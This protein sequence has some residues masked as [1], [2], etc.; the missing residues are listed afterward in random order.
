MT[1]KNSPLTLRLDAK[2]HKQLLAEAEKQRVPL[3]D[4]GC[5]I[6]EDYVA[7]GRYAHQAKVMLFRAPFIDIVFNQIPEETVKKIGK[8]VGA[9]APKRMMAN[10][11]MPSTL[12]NTIIL[13]QNILDKRNQWFKARIEREDDVLDL[14]LKH[15]INSKWSLFLGE[16]TV[17]M[18]N[19]FG[20]QKTDE[21]IDDYE[22]HLRFKI[23]R[24]L[25]ELTNVPDHSNA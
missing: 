22:A 16:F 2:I 1:K 8:A 3:E 5:S 9:E 13:I 15:N 20:L 10:L 17:T 4:L 25:S 7:F 21:D 18:F 12:E 11:K 24:H 19:T 6:L 23:P 14:Y